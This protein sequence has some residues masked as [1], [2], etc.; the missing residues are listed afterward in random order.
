MSRVAIVDGVRTPFVKAGGAFAHVSAQELG[1]VALRELLERTEAEP[2]SINETIIGN[3]AQP[4]DAT[5]ISRVISLTAGLPLSSSAHTV[6]RN[7]A[8]GLQSIA[9]GF[10]LIRAGRAEAIIVGGTESMSN[11]P[12]VFPRVMG[13]FLSSLMQ[14]KT[15]VAKIRALTR[16]RPRYMKPIVA[17]LE[18]LTDPFCGLNMGQT[19]EVLAKEFH[20]TREEQD[21][22]ALASHQKAVAATKEGRLREEIV[23]YFPAESGNAVAE[24][25]GPRANQT[26]E[27]LAKLPPYFD[28]RHGTVTAGNSCGITDGAAMM[29]LMSEERLRRENRE[30]LGW[31]RG[32]AF[33]GL[34]PKRMGLG[35]AV[36]TALALRSTGLSMSDMELVEINEAFAAQVLANLKIFE[37]PSL[38]AGVGVESGRLGAINPEILNV[39]GGAI[40]F[41]HPVGTSGTR[42]TLTLAR[43]MKRRNL[44]HG[45]ATLCVGGGQGGAMI[46]ERG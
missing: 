10:E 24:D 29:L 41:G 31:I 30:P 43:E 5:N 42:I 16:F 39:N 44:T 1:R 38:G 22:F 13:D 33:A 15:P 12:L 34:D 9:E 26:M 3:V 23:S 17:L 32:Y 21:R 46:L 37:N 36:S 35:P 20:V 19:A 6:A 25:I 4:M 45:L 2:Q 40:A 7:C 27:A 28:R 8:S 11:I 14:A 18:G